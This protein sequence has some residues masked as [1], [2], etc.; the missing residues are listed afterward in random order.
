MG[1]PWEQRKFEDIVV[2]SSVKSSES[3]LPRIE[4]EDIISG[5]GQLNKNWITKENKKAG[6]LFN[7][8]DILYG[9]L[10]PYLQNWFLPS[11]KGIAVGDFWVLK[12]QNIDSSFLYMIIQ[13]DQFNEIA[14]QSIGSKMPRADWNLVSKGIFLIPNI[15]E[16]IKIG[17]F[18][19]NFDNL[20]TLHQRQLFQ[21]FF[22][23]SFK[24]FIGI[25]VFC[26]P[27]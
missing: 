21:P 8:G 3:D 24:I 14:N 22:F 27:P 9:K 25:T 5:T 4:Y 26:F 7:Q 11:F 13:S 10:R 17:S 23:L 6:S 1:S 12:P 16:Q 19:S 15:N 20:I 2:R 18:F